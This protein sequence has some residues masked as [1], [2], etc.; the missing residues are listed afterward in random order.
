MWSS[1]RREACGK[2]PDTRR[3]RYACIVEAHE[4]T[5]NRLERTLPKITKI[6]LL[7]GVQFIE[8]LKTC[9]ISMPQATKIPDAQAA[10]DKE[11]EKNSQNFP[12]LQMTKVRSKKKVIK[13][14]QKEERTVQF[15]TRMDIC[16]Q[17][18][19]ELK[20]GFQKYKGRV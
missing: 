13:E 10:V 4:S 17:K 3:S 18:K 8:S 14:A 6:A 1:Q 20:P 5:R 15:A 12:A 2:E 11:C 16:H 7:R 9:D 19:S